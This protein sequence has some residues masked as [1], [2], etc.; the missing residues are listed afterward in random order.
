MEALDDFFR[1]GGAALLGWLSVLMLRNFCDRLAGQLGA[2]SAASSA[3]YLVGAQTDVYVFGVQ[4]QYLFLPIS[5]VSA[6]LTWLFCLTQFDDNFRLE[7]VHKLVV[8]VKLVAGLAT[9]PAMM[10]EAD[11]LVAALAAFSRLIILGV[12]VHLIVVIWQGQH[13]DLVEDRR[14]VRSIFTISVVAIS[15]AILVMETTPQWA[16]YMPYWDVIQSFSFAAIAIFLLWRLADPAGVDLFYAE[17]LDMESNRV[18]EPHC[19]LS[20][21][22]QHDLNIINTFTRSDGILE[23]GLTISKLSQSVH[24]PEHRLRHL[25]NQHMGYRNFADFVNHHRIEAAKQQLADMDKRNTPVLTLAMDL[26]YGSL[27]PFNRAFKERTGLTPTEFRAQ[28]M[29]AGLVAAK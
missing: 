20:A 9:Y 8:T 4:A 22:D 2:L 28:S 12:V 18:I 3:I 7:T 5:S 21:T 1:Y 26:G 29:E 16:A 24:I 14:K 6:V 17:P 11:G 15:I 23:G 13:D 19:E 27:G 25:I 10:M